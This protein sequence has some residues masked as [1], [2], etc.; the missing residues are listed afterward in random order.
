[1]TENSRRRFLQNSLMSL[2]ALPLSHRTIWASGGDVTVRLRRDNGRVDLEVSDTGMG[3]PE[4]EQGRLFD[5]F[6]R[7]SN[8]NAQAIPGTGLGLAIV[9]AIVEG[10]GGELG[11]ES[12]E[13]VGTTMTIRLPL[14]LD[15]APRRARPGN[16]ARPSTV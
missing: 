10:H 13:G 9:R 2:L 14:V 11:F 12:T 6:F 7:A 5:R 4:D 1:M 3:I 8:A 16:A 15:T